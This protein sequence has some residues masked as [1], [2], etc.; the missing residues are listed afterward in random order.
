MDEGLGGR[1]V[2]EALLAAG[3][4][5]ER[6][7]THFKPGTPDVE[8][9]AE[10]AQHRWMILTKDD[11]I[12]RNPLERLVVRQTGACVFALGSQQMTGSAMAATFVLARHRMKLFARKHQG[13]FIARVHRD[14]K[15]TMW[16]SKEDL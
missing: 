7:A 15:V 11:G 6:H 1:Q 4:R 9:M 10:A 14:G 2:V 5:V 16:K 12:G 3:E 13:A 8:W